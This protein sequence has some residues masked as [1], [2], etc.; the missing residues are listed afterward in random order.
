MENLLCNFRCTN[1]TLNQTVNSISTAHKVTVTRAV[2]EDSHMCVISTDIFQRLCNLLC[3]LEASPSQMLYCR[4]EKG[5]F[6][7]KISGKK[8]RPHC[9]LEVNTAFVKRLTV[10]T[11]CQVHFELLMYEYSH[12]CIQSS[13]F[14]QA[15]STIKTRLPSDFCMCTSFIRGLSC[16]NTKYC[17]IY[18]FGYKNIIN[19]VLHPYHFYIWQHSHM[20]YIYMNLHRFIWKLAWRKPFFCLFF[21]FPLIN[22]SLFNIKP[23]VKPSP[24]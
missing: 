18:S 5:S 15:T 24:I 16:N 11:K 12:K 3:P 19:L 23:K 9:C 22:Q 6:N 14:M 4:R 2:H 17:P 1:F 21:H 7:W 13:T 8:T 10:K 20:C